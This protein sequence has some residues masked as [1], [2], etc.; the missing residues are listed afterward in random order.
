M[1]TLSG[2]RG[3]HGCHDATPQTGQGGTGHGTPEVG[4]RALASEQ[5]ARVMQL[6]HRRRLTDRGVL[7]VQPRTRS[8]AVR[9]WIPSGPVE[10][11]VHGQDAAEAEA[12]TVCLCCSRLRRGRAGGR[13][14]RVVRSR[15]ARAGG[16]TTWPGSGGRSRLPQPRA[17]SDVLRRSADTSADVLRGKAVRSDAPC[18]WR[19]RTGR[20]RSPGAP[21]S[22][23]SR[24]RGCA[25]RQRANFSMAAGVTGVKKLTRLPSGS[26]NSSDRLPQG[27][28]V[29]PLTKSVT[30]P[31][32]FW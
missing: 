30:K 17:R 20:P 27:I 16:R 15:R 21:G 26:R 9:C 14:G 31:V 28:V 5:A 3:L 7:H 1:N 10:D 18:W 6:L 24:L 4:S 12:E 23:G 32:R 11:D 29:G 22:R 19:S 8:L 25:W 2:R 13:S